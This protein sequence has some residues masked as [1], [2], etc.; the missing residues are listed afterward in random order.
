MLPIGLGLCWRSKI[1]WLALFAYMLVGTIWHIV[2]GTLDSQLAFL[3]VL[4]PVLNIPLV[5][6]IYFVTRPVFTRH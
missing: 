1:A 6:G 3:A 5:V 4:S 2:A